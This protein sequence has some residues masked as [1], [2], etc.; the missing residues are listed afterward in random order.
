VERLAKAWVNLLKALRVPLETMDDVE[1]A[2]LLLVTVANEE[3]EQIYPLGSKAGTT[4]KKTA[5]PSNR[6]G[7]GGGQGTK[8]S[9]GGGGGSGVGGAGA[10]RG[11][12]FGGGGGRGGGQGGWGGRGGGR[13]TFT[14]TRTPSTPSTPFQT[15]SKYSGFATPRPTRVN[16]GR[17]PARYTPHSG[18]R[19]MNAVGAEQQM[20]FREWQDQVNAMHA[21]RTSHSPPD[22]GGSTTDSKPVNN[23]EEAPAPSADES[24]TA[25]QQPR[26]PTSSGEGQQAQPSYG[27]EQVEEVKKKK[28]K[29][30]S[31]RK[32]AVQAGELEREQQAHLPAEEQQAHRG[33][34]ANDLQKRMRQERERRSREHEENNFGQ[35]RAQP[36]LSARDRR[37]SSASNQD[38]T[39]AFAELMQISKTGGEKPRSI[40]AISA[41]RLGPISQVEIDALQGAEKSR[42]EMTA[43]LRRFLPFTRGSSEEEISAFGENVLKIKLLLGDGRVIEG[44]VDTGAGVTA[45]SQKCFDKLPDGQR[46]KPRRSRMTLV[47]ACK[48]TMS[49]QGVVDL[50]VRL[51]EDD[52]KNKTAIKFAKPVTIGD[53]E[54]LRH[55]NYDFVLGMPA[56]KA[57]GVIVDTGDSKV[58]LRD[59][60]T[61][62]L[63]EVPTSHYDRNKDTRSPITPVE[64]SVSAMRRVHFGGVKEYAIPGLLDESSSDES[65]SDES[66]S[67]DDPEDFSS[68]DYF[69]DEKDPEEI[70]PELRRQLREAKLNALKHQTPAY[71]SKWRA[72]PPMKRRS[73]FSK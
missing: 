58:F 3:G 72:P 59:P 27:Q 38:P 47:S 64:T 57:L 53:V 17:P 66:S 34:A 44:L 12:G 21:S 26:H 71:Q 28:K 62:D 40:G 43:D 50:P 31:S 73:L 13:P 49:S 68:D 63:R 39:A 7:G 42:Q 11:G 37:V 19:S 8:G 6:N 30:K 52:P 46:P 18:A 4:P 15:P 51:Q 5:V 48:T 55:L 14:P 9:G 20:T 24:E 54:I 23:L 16:A 70:P 69:S 45:L 41:R 32:K 10:G 29:K 2:V 60:K 33:Y 1:K 25:S 61:G 22:E 35:P 67:D 56:L 36:A 65:S